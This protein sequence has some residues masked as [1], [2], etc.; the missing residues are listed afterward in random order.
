FKH[1]FFFVVVS[2]LL[3]AA[4]YFT[5]GTLT[6]KAK[7]IYAAAVAFYPLY[8]GYQGF[9]L[10]LLPERWRVMLDPMML[11]AV[12]IP[13]GKWEDAAWVNQIVVSYS[14]NM[15]MNRAVM[16]AVAVILLMI[17]CLRFAITTA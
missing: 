2:H 6:R 17:L 8:I 10:K 9:L 1:F 13:R 12:N 16:V 14:A 15:I 5:I 4:V 11:N 7:L 3:L